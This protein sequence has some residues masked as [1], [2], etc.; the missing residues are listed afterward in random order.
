MEHTPENSDIAAVFDHIAELL[1]AQGENPF[2]IR[3]YRNAVRTL[4]GLN[5]PASTIAA[6]GELRKI[7]GFGEAIAA[8]TEEI[9]STGT[10]ELYERLKAETDRPATE[11]KEEKRETGEA[12]GARGPEPQIVPGHEDDDE[13]LPSPW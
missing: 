3:A 11:I 1:E 4:D 5:E 13:D 12:L 7:P 2:K 9:L 6:R 8:K 10:C